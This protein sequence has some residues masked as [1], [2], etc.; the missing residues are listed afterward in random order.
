[1]IVGITFCASVVASINIMCGGG[2]SNVFNSAL[3]APAVNM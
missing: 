3:K 2:S 1:M